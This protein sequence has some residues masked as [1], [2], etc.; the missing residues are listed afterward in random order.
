[1][2]PPGRVTRT[3]SFATSNGLGAN[4][5][6]KMLTTRSN[7]PSSSPA[8]SVASP[9]WKRQLPSPSARA[10]VARL[11][12]VARDVDAEHVGAEPGLGQRGGAVAAAEV[13]H[14]QPFDD[15]QAPDQRLTAFAHARRQICVAGP[16]RRITIPLSRSNCDGTSAFDSARISNC[17]RPPKLLPLSPR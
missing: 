3:I 8:R 10:A 2:R 13:E 17:S 4:I 15:A 12:Q 14:L 5:A 6:P 11:D 7:E 1:M 16:A 9:S